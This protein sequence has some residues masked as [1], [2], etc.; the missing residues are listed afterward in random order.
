MTRPHHYHDHR[1]GT[2]TF[3]AVLTVVAFLA[4]FG[5]VVLALVDAYRP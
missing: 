3:A 4:A 5:V 1:D 2:E